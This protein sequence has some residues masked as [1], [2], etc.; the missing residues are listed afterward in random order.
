EYN[1]KLVEHGP[2]AASPRLFAYT[3]SSAA[4]GEV[5]IALGIKGANVTSHA[6]LAAGLQAIG[7]GF[8]LI[9]MGKADVVLAGGADALGAALV[10]GLADM[11]LLKTRA[12]QAFRSPVAGV[13]PAEGAAVV[14]LERG[15][16]ALRRGARVLARIDG[17]AAGFEPSLTQ[18]RREPTAIAETMCRALALSGRAAGDVGVVITS[19]HATAL[20]ALELAALQ[21]VL[22]D[23]TSPVLCAPKA[24]CGETFGA[25]GALGVALATA[26]FNEPARAADNVAFGLDGV[27]LQAGDAQNRLQRA[28]L[29]LI[30]ALCYSGPTVTLVLAREN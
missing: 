19:A 11:Q 24:A 6:G 21:S 10:R 25:H 3:V 8:D 12:A 28:R 18:R 16:R 2:T 29:A 5:S 14:V 26:L 15:D 27:S 30:H 7:Y 22:A 23:S 17:Y 20:D 9:R 1:Q 4:A 13:C